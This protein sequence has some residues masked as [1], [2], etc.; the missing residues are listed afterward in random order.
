MQIGENL[1][2]HLRARGLSV[3]DL[4]A[5][6]GLTRDDIQSVLYNRSKK[7]EKLKI[8]ADALNIPLSNLMP[9]ILQLPFRHKIYELAVIVVCKN[10]D[11]FNISTNKETFDEYVTEMYNYIAE[12][13]DKAEKD[14]LIYCEG[15]LRGA[16]NTGVITIQEYP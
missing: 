13:K 6:T 4:E 8:I 14:F 5:K 3:P 7:P 2:K 10:L 16:I 12:N 15:M 11:F 1:K 9:K